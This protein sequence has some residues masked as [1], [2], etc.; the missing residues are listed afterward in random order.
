MDIIK[1]VTKHLE[2]ADAKFVKNPSPY[3]DVRNRLRMVSGKLSELERDL[4]DLENGV[5]SDGDF[6][7]EC[8]GLLILAAA[9]YYHNS[10][11]VDPRDNAFPSPVDYLNNDSTW[12]FGEL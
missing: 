10:E 9:L 11:F 12:E 3:S 6:H 1:A 2:E 4:R 7:A 8:A 5:G